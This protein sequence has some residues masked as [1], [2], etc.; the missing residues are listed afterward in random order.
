MR[1]LLFIAAAL[2]ATTPVGAQDGFSL[3]PGAQSQDDAW[4]SSQQWALTRL[5]A[6]PGWSYLDG[7]Y[8]RR[9]D[10]NGTGEKPLP[11]DTVTVHFAGTFVDG[12]TFDSSFGGGRP[13]T[14]P[15]ARVVRAWQ[16]AIPQM[17]VGD[18]IEIVSPA[19]LGYGPA[20]RG[21]IPGGATLMFKVQLLGI[22]GR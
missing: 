7:L 9:I 11:T 5:A 15:L 8:W 12:T 22:T 16:L 10:G 2:T 19:S 1:K 18:T 13:A 14:F 20:G 3:T 6:D 17:G 21:S 4:Q